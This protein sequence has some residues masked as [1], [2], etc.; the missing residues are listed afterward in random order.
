MTLTRTPA[1]FRNRRE[2]RAIA[3]RLYVRGLMPPYV[4]KRTHRGVRVW[5]VT[6]PMEPA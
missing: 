4:I 5:I 6:S 2:A 1:V 3:G